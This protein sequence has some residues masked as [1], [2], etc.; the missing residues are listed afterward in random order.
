MTLPRQFVTK[1][2]FPIIQRIS[3]KTAGKWGMNLW[4]TPPRRKRSESERLFLD[5][6]GKKRIP[7]KESRH[8]GTSS[9]Y[10]L[11]SWGKGPRIL[12]VHDW[13]GGASQ[14]AFLSKPLVEAGFQVLAFD[15]LAHGDSSGSRTDVL[16]IADVIRDID[17]KCG[18]FEAVIAHSLGALA[19]A[20]A[21]QDGVRAEKLVTCAAAAS[22]DYYLKRFAEKIK[23]SRQTLGKIAFSMNHRFKTN[24][25]QLSLINLATCL[26]KPVLILHDE[27]DE[28]IDH[29]EALALSKCWPG[30]QLMLTRG[31]GHHGLLRDVQVIT[32]LLQ[33]LH[34]KERLPERV[35]V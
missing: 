33:F 27:H 12:L 18:E 22:L 26:Q 15:A 14:L 31:L 30:S 28:I 3:P 9:Y 29:R 4:Y 10:T 8:D 5:T 32:T 35:A 19:A 17:S 13:G 25:N 1:F 34:R 21:I 23:A 7:F 6:A 20:I 24:I 11:Y 16:E 2:G